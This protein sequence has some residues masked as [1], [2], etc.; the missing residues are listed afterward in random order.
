VCLLLLLGLQLLLLE[1]LLLLEQLLEHGGLL[2]LLLGL[3]SLVR[4]RG[5]LQL[6]DKLLI[7]LRQGL[8][9][10]LEESHLALQLFHGGGRLALLDEGLRGC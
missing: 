4:L 7:L 9:L 3:S 10:L 2:L 1:H 8:Q 5:L 6:F